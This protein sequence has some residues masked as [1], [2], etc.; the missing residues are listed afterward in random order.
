AEALRAEYDKRISTGRQLR[1]EGKIDDRTLRARAREAAHRFNA[2]LISGL[3]ELKLSGA[4]DEAEFNRLAR[5]LRS[6]GLSAGRQM[7]QG[8][9]SGGKSGLER[10][11]VWVKGIFA[12]QLG[13][14]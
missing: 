3:Q 8:V 10:L 1:F 9:E 2:A 11:L 13:Q 4:I 14:L 7:S 5:R 6:A 12:I